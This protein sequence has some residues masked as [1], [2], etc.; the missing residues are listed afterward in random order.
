MSFLSRCTSLAVVVL[1]LMLIQC[2]H[3]KGAKHW[4][5]QFARALPNIE[6][7]EQKIVD[8][9]LQDLNEIELQDSSAII[10]V[11]SDDSNV[12][13]AYKE[14]P[15]SEINDG[16]WN[17]SVHVEAIF[18]G[19]AQIFVEIG[20]QVKSECLVERSNSFLPIQVIRKRVPTWMYNEMYNVFEQVLYVIIG[21]LFGMATDWHKVGAHLRKP[22]GVGI[23]FFCSYIFMPLVCKITAVNIYILLIVQN[24]FIN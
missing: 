18:I 2:L 5:V 13:N 15:I 8:F 22:V 6:I 24:Y 17:G 3:V 10:R 19:G 11:L 4:R 14:I 16:K 12:I 21:I 23:S 20:R 9:K 1:L 7:G